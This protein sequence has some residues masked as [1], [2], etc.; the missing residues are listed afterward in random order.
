MNSRIW[1]VVLSKNQAAKI[2]RQAVYDLIE[3]RWR[4]ER[5][6]EL[7]MCKGKDDKEEDVM[8]LRRPVS[9]LNEILSLWNKQEIDTVTVW[10]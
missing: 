9:E 3:C 5:G 7:R 1:K 4:V 2:K 10:Q 8:S 6:R